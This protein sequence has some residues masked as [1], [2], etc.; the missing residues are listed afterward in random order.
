[1]NKIIIIGIVISIIIGVS[2]ISI[3]SNSSGNFDEILPDEEIQNE[4]NQFTVGLDE[5][6]GVSGG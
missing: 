5:S 4:P 6:V 1:M 3:S 2:I